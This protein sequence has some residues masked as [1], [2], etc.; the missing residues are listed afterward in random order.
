MRKL[1]RTRR[2]LMIDIEGGSVKIMTSGRREAR[3]FNTENL[4]PR[5]M[6]ETVLHLARD[7]MFDVVLSLSWVGQA[8][9]SG[10]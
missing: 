9:T 6:V 1:K 10:R 8:R 3:S 4:R 2:V 7:W 5:P